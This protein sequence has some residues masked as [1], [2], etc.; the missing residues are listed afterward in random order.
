MSLHSPASENASGTETSA[1][2]E[3]EAKAWT[4]TSATRSVACDGAFE[5][6]SASCGASPNHALLEYLA[7]FYNLENREAAE[8]ILRWIGNFPPRRRPGSEIQDMW[9][10]A[11]SMRRHS[12]QENR[13]SKAELKDG[14]IHLFEMRERRLLDSAIER[15]SLAPRPPK[16][17]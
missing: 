7:G 10:T 12:P 14:F 5:N 3:P 16:R 8:S 13:W 15:S 2:V 17:I 1:L 11:G 4:T 9:R 6:V